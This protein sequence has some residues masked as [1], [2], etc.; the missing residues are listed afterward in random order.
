MS[1]GESQS[2]KPSDDQGQAERA[3]EMS[4]FFHLPRSSTWDPQALC[5]DLTRR[6][7]DACLEGDRIVIVIS[8]DD[9]DVWRRKYDKR[10]RQRERALRGAVPP[11][12]S[13]R[14]FPDRFLRN[15]ELHHDNFKVPPDEPQLQVARDSII[16]FGAVALDSI[17]AEFEIAKRTFANHALL[18]EYLSKIQSCAQEKVRLVAEQKFD[19]AVSARDEENRL[20]GELEDL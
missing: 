5:H 20:R 14:R 7:L 4:Q 3:P 10:I 8:S 18:D 13:V 1:I 6:G 15:I 12:A 9:C 16:E 11:D 2:W 19:A 17:E